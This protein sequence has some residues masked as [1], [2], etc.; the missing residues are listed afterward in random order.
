VNKIDQVVQQY[1]RELGDIREQLGAERTRREQAEEKAR[2]SEQEAERLRE[3]LE[4]ER[5]KG[6]WRRLFGG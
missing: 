6:F 4:A 2:A 1:T 3:E 5:S